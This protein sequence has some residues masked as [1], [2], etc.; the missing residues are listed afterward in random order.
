MSTYIF[1]PALAA[2]LILAV[3]MGFWRFA[4]TELYP[5]M[6]AD[7]AL[8]LSS[9]SFVATANYLGYLLGALLVTSSSA[10]MA[11]MLCRVA[12]LGTALCLGAMAMDAGLWFVICVR[13]LAGVISAVAMA[14]SSA[15]LMQITA[16]Q[17]AGHTAS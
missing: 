15:W 14:A 2:A 5:M 8:T 6:V 4:C 13:L 3:G 12:M 1:S 11:P 17:S 9:G 10:K 16:A 7:G